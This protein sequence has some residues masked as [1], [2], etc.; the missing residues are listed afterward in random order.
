[1]RDPEQLDIEDYLALLDGYEPWV[2]QPDE[3]QE[4]LHA[5][6]LDSEDFT[7]FAQWDSSPEVQ[8]TTRRAH[9]DWLS[10]R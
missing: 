4:G 8:E 2:D 7:D 1:M 3:G 10:A 5:E 6:L 9:A